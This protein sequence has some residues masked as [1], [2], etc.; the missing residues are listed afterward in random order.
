MKKR[1]IFGSGIIT[2]FAALTI[3]TPFAFAQSHSIKGVVASIKQTDGVA[4]WLTVQNKEESLSISVL[5]PPSIQV[6]DEVNVAY[7]EV[8]D[9]LL[10]DDIAVTAEQAN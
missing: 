9:I 8:A 2:A 7:H 4:I 10:A 3:L 6:G 1:S 5:N